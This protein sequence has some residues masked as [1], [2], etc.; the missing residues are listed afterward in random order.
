MR[1]ILSSLLCLSLLTGCA[2]ETALRF[3]PEATEAGTPQR[4]YFSTTRGDDGLGDPYSYERSADLRYGRFEVSIPPDREL[5]SLPLP[6]AEG[7]VDPKKHIYAVSATGFDA[8]GFR[9][10][11]RRDL[12]GNPAG[13]R[14][15]V[16]FVHGYNNNFASGLYRFAQLSHDLE[17]SGVQVQYSWP[18]R[19]SVLGYAYDRDSVLFARDG[20]EDLLAELS[21]AGADRIILVAHSMGAQLTMETLRQIAHKRRDGL[22]R[23]LA[24]VVLISPDI[25]LS[26]FRS[27]ARAFDRLPQ[28]F[29]VMASPRDKALSLSAAI[30]R[31]SN[32]LGNLTDVTELEGLGVTLIDVGAFTI[33]DGHFNAATSP[34]LIQLLSKAGDIETALARDARSRVGL[35][36]GAVLSVQGATQVILSPVLRPGERIGG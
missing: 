16:V 17:V 6:P 5:G 4:V 12:R 7:P 25:D 3:A 33:G 2:P 35:L 29:V 8:A 14:E 32:R 26:V 24:G 23:S 13:K 1:P 28:P 34:A 19:N 15:A 27:Q 20:L 10:A 21:M 31:D 11:L 22:L 9:T 18:S 30:S 36:P